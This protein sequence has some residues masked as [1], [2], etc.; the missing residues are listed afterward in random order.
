MN[1]YTGAYYLAIA[2]KNGASPGRPLVHTM[3]DSGRPT[4]E[5]ETSCLRIRGLP[6][7]YRVKSSKGIQV[8]TTKKSLPEINACRTINLTDIVRYRLCR[9]SG[10]KA[11]HKNIIWVTIL[12]GRSP[13]SGNP[14]YIYP[15]TAQPPARPFSRAQY[16]QTTG[17]PVDEIEVYQRHS[18]AEKW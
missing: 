11:T 17:K 7:L 1:I 3:L 13:G 5:P 9:K 8:P 10:W 14:S 6:D 2:F 18:D 4:P 16:L 15:V 12:T